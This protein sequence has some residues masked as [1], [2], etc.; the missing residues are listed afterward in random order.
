M[1]RWKVKW[2]G[3]TLRRNSLVIDGREEKVR[4]KT[5]AAT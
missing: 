4:K 2:I 5:Q 3:H 1:K